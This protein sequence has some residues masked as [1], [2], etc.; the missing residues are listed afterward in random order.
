M[1]SLDHLGLEV[2]SRLQKE[3]YPLAIKNVE[4]MLKYIDFH[5]TRCDNETIWFQV[6]YY[7]HANWHG[8]L[9]GKFSYSCVALGMCAT[10]ELIVNEYYFSCVYICLFEFINFRLKYKYFIKGLFY[11]FFRWKCKKTGLASS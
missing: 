11:M 1:P 5:K 9:P 3:S 10:T 7:R 4:I 8:T 2:W 6:L